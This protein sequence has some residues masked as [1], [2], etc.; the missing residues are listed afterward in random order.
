VNLLQVPV[1]HGKADLTPY[2]NA[3]AAVAAILDKRASR[4][5]KA[6]IDEV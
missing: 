4:C 3:G 6:S 1:K 5:E 2:R